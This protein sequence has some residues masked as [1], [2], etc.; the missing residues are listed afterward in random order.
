MLCAPSGRRGLAEPVEDLHDQGELLLEV[1]IE[2]VG[3]AY[4]EEPLR[5]RLL[6]F[7]QLNQCFLANSLRFSGSCSIIP[8]RNGRR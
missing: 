1:R 2:L 3:V 8:V 4:G 6:I 7:P 5:Q